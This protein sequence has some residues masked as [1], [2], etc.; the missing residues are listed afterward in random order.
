MKVLSALVLCLMSINVVYGISNSPKRTI[1]FKSARKC[2]KENGIDFTIVT[3]FLKGDF[4]KETE[5]SKVR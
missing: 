5:D 3:K 1:V 2:A 4:S